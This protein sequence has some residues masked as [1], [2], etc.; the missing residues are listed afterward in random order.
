MLKEPLQNVMLPFE[1][2]VSSKRN[3]AIDF[4][5]GENGNKHFSTDSM[6][7]NLNH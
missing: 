5:N 3:V 6:A 4:E 1:F 7:K 2:S